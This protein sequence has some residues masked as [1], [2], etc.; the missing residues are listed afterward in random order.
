VPIARE[1][2]AASECEVLVVHV[3]DRELCCKGPAWEKPMTCTP[4][5]LVADLVAELRRAGVDARGEV[6]SSLN[7]R[8]AD[9]ILATAQDFGADLIVAGWRRQRT[10]GGLLEKSTGQKI[11]ERSRTPFLLVP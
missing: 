2:A 8:E 9:E 11:A 3:R 7:H 10:L 6:H 5:E 4:D 1:L